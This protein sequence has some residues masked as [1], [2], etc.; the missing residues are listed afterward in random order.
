MWPFLTHRVVLFIGVATKA[1]PSSGKGD[2][3]PHLLMG[4]MVNIGSRVSN[5]ATPVSVTLLLGETDA[6]IER[7][8]F[9]SFFFR[10]PLL[11]LQLRFYLD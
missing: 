4:G 9:L 1:H 7:L 10:P 5:P 11:H 3:D 6:D 8:I 2:I